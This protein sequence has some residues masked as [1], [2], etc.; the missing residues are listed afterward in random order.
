MAATIARTR[1]LM[2][3]V[4]GTM[5]K[6]AKVTMMAGVRYTSILFSIYVI[7][8]I[9]IREQWCQESVNNN[10]LQ[11][12]NSTGRSAVVRTEAELPPTPISTLFGGMLRTSQSRGTRARVADNA[13][14]QPFFVL[15][16]DVQVR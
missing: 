2:A 11:V 3:R 8:A 12:V 15:S 5:S 4:P 14:I 7:F 6:M 10:V 13:Q 1:R 9:A 16:L